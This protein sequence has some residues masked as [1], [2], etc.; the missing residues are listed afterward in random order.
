MSVYKI[1]SYHNLT[2]MEMSGE[3]DDTHS[4]ITGI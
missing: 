2:F 1:P 3:V 4:N